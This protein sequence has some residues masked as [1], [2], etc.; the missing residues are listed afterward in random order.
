M[1]PLHH[2][3]DERCERV[4]PGLLA[5][6]EAADR[7][8]LEG[9]G[10]PGI[11][12]FR[13]VGGCG[14]LIPA[15]YGGRGASPADVL[16]VQL[17]MGAR[18]LSSAVGLAMHLFTTATLVEV[19][20][21][22]EGMEWLVVEAIATQDL[23]E[24]SAFAEGRPDAK[25]LS[26]TMHLEADGP[27]YRLS[28]AKRPCSLCTSMD[29]VTVSVS[30][31]GGPDDGSFAI[32]L[33]PASGAG[34]TATERWDAP[35]LAGAQ[36]GELVFDHVSVPRSALSYVGTPSAVDVSQIRGYAWFELCIS[37]AYL[38]GAHGM[39]E[40]VRVAGRFDESGLL[41][42]AV[43]LTTARA[44]LAGLAEMLAAGCCDDAFLAEV[45]SVR[46]GVERSIQRITDVAAEAAGVQMLQGSWPVM[47]LLTAT[48]ALAYH[49]PSRRRAGP[50][51]VR[52]L[53][54]GVLEL[55]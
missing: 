29:M 25:V 55:E 24:A 37:A 12:A 18:S 22:S 30:L 21:R 33:L 26:P 46:Y 23:L 45:L 11:E 47:Q 8:A 41:Q 43:E 34:L 51:L 3:T 36:T 4:L 32:A 38:G 19:I 53:D 17:S 44:A 48:R 7:A 1:P 27:A 40:A 5:E 20:G 10:N 6:L 16:A 13:R 52:F 28:G 31:P 54:S 49:P 42:V 15:D 50:G 39:A 35:V 9:P 14:L 2:R